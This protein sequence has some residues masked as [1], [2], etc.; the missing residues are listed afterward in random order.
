M[1]G[2]TIE[3]F[4]SMTNGDRAFERGEHGLSV[5]CYLRA[6]AIAES[7][8]GDPEFMQPVFLAHCHAS[9]SG[10]LGRLG[11]HEE[12]LAHSE[13]A[14]QVYERCGQFYPAE[15]GRWF[16]AWFN[17]GAALNALGHYE[18][19]TAAL[20]RAQAILGEDA[21]A[22]EPRRMCR[23]AIRS[24]QHNQRHTECTEFERQERHLALAFQLGDIDYHEAVEKMSME[25]SSLSAAYELLKNK[26][27]CTDVE[28]AFVGGYHEYEELLPCLAPRS[29]RR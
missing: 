9:V 7:R 13:Q 5:A 19:A 14:I 6:I 28:M 27:D 17:K 2:D 10:S 25:Y 1:G 4:T 18:E 20:Q 26:P 24:V 12:S 21:E 3:M 11:R 16:Q 8:T 23:D 29:R 15:R 22:E